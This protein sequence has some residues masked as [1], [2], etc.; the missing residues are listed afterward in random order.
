MK[1]IILIPL[2]FLAATLFS[3]DLSFKWSEPVEL[4]KKVG[5][6]EEIIGSNE[7]TVFTMKSGRKGKKLLAYDK[8]SLKVKKELLLKGAK[9]S[10][11]D[12][13]EY[14]KLILAFFQISSDKI[15]IFFRE[16]KKSI[17]KIYYLELTS[18]LVAVGKLTMLHE[19]EFDRSSVTRTSMVRNSNNPKSNI[20]L[21]NEKYR[22]ENIVAEYKVFNSEMKL[23]DVG[24]I[25]LPFSIEKKERTEYIQRAY[26]LSDDNNI[27]STITKTKEENPGAPRRKRW[28][29]FTAVGLTDLSSGDSKMLT[30]KSDERKYDDVRFVSNGEDIF[31]AGFYYNPD[32]D[33][34]FPNVS[35]F[36]STKVNFQMGSM[37]EVQ[38]FEY[39]ENFFRHFKNNEKAEESNR[40]A[41]KEEKRAKYIIERMVI[42]DIAIGQDG[43]NVVCSG[44]ANKSVTTCNSKG[45][46]TTR[47]YC[48]KYGVI[49]FSTDK[50]MKVKSYDVLPR[51]MVYSGSN[52]MDVNITPLKNNSYMVNFGSA[53]ELEDGAMTGNPKRKARE[54][55]RSQFEYAILNDEGV[56]E[57][58]NMKLSSVNGKESKYFDFDELGAVECFGEVFV[59]CNFN[60]DKKGQVALGK[61]IEK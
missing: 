39:D 57:R 15:Y 32:D 44:M 54:I 19:I 10:I 30:L 58:R 4:E 24:K 59:I 9:G 8:A 16:E 28:T 5:L 2:C 46:C 25:D 18:D 1:K 23:A 29:Y 3:Q 40:K 49:S 35:G 13:K 52:I 7:I 14:S 26:R 42:E 48:Y 6:S 22:D 21:V 38:L 36:Y 27:L 50:N 56:L 34:D 51:L 37:S 47:Y 31:L 45:A 12:N 43:M 55:L 53:F 20:V 11:L 60:I 41:K 33:G 17:E 61:V